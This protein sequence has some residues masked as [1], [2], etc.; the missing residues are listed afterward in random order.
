ML[1]HVQAQLTCG[2]E[3]LVDHLAVG[4]ALQPFPDERGKAVAAMRVVEPFQLDQGVSPVAFGDPGK[5]S[6]DPNRG[7]LWI[8]QGLVERPV[9]RRRDCQEVTARVAAA[10][11]RGMGMPPEMTAGTQREAVT[12]RPR[13][14]RRRTPDWAV[15]PPPE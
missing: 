7:L 3:Q 11:W 4:A 12:A 1:D 13:R 8:S 2:L 9:Q 6:L 5:G 15:G 14:V 10:P